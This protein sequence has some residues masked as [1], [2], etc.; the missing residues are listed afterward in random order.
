MSAQWRIVRRFTSIAAGL[1]VVVLIAA[2]PYSKAASEGELSHFQA[3]T[4]VLL[5]GAAASQLVEYCG[6]MRGTKDGAW[7]PPEADLD[8]LDIELAPLLAADLK[9]EGSKASA[10]QY[11]RQYAA[12]TWQKHKVIYVNG[13]HERH[14][15]SLKMASFPIDGWKREAVVVDDGGPDYWC[16]IFIKDT[17]KFVA[18]KHEG[19]PKRTVAFHGYA[20]APPNKSLER[21]REG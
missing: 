15:E 12:G 8:A 13:F 11:Y 7:K 19:R 6:R 2:A 5:E 9:S 16:A 21:T 1:I 14:L 10:D 3:N 20:W 17:G 18:I 4:R